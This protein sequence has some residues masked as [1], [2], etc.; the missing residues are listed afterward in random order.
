MPIYTA[1]KQIIKVRGLTWLSF[2]CAIGAVWAGIHLAQTYG[3]APGDGGVLRPLAVRLAWGIGVAVLGL[4]FAAGMIVYNRQ[5]IARMELLTD[6]RTVAI[7]TIRPWG[8]HTFQVQAS[9]I[10][11]GRFHRGQWS[12]EGLTVDAP[13]VAVHIKGHRLAYI[14]DLQGQFLD[15]EAARMVLGK[16]KR[17]MDMG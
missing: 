6:G 5:Y 9:D 1:H 3:L 10:D 11:A 8:V 12:A 7:S 4:L 14:L 17:V 16:S 15:A 2:V 13:W